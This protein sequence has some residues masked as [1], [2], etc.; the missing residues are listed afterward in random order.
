MCTKRIVTNQIT[1]NFRLLN[2]DDDDRKRLQF[3][4]HKL[5]LIFYRLFFHKIKY[6]FSWRFDR[7]N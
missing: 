2:D 5:S 3:A 7:V 4:L 1:S 6:I